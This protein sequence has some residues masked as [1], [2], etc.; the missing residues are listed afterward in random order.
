MLKSTIVKLLHECKC[1]GFTTGFRPLVTRKKK[2]VVIYGKKL[3]G[4]MKLRRIRMMGR[5]R[6]GEGEKQ[7]MFRHKPHYLSH[8]VEEM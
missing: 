1:T 5:K 7:V 2:A 6:F 4:Q 8:M 3:F